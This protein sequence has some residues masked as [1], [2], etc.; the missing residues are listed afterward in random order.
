MFLHCH[1]C[2]WEQDDFWTYRFSKNDILDFLKLKWLKRPFGYN[3]ES[4]LLEDIAT[5]LP[6]RKIKMDVMWCKERGINGNK[7]HSWYLLKKSFK[8][9]FNVRK[10][11]KWTTYKKFRDDFEKGNAECPS[12]GSKE[13]FDVD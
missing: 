13:H 3:P 7:V 9:Y 12:C 5:W 8:R 1:N 4:I 10:N 6:P 2:G 11:M